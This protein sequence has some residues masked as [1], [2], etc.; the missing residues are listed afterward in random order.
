[1]PVVWLWE[2]QPMYR[3][4]SIT[5]IVKMNCPC[6]IGIEGMQCIL[7]VSWD[8]DNPLSKVGDMRDTV[9]QVKCREITITLYN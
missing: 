3:R 7:T 8:T 9:G 4:N 2:I 1:M 5:C 6:D